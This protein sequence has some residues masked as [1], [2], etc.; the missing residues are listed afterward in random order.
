MTPEINEIL[1]R[2]LI[3]YGKPT[4]ILMA[5][6]ECAELSQALLHHLR[7]RKADVVGE[8]ADVLIVAQQMRLAFG[9]AEVDRAIAEK[10]A[11]LAVRLE[12]SA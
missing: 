6:E 5:V 10:A 1:T 9:P 4:Q 11:R 12:E 2:A 7:G 3:T 8:I